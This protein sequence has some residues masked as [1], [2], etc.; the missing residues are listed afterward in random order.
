MPKFQI[1]YNHRRVKGKI[2][3]IVIDL[4]P[5]KNNLNKFSDLNN[6]FDALEKKDFTTLEIENDLEL[7]IRNLENGKLYRLKDDGT[8]L[9]QRR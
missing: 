2:G 1:N 7:L 6:F 9:E 5:E 8:G 3:K 4:E